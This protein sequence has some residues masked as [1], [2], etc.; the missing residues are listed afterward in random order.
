MEVGLIAAHAAHMSLP[1][2]IEEVFNMPTHN[3]AQ[4]LRLDNYG[5]KEGNRADLVVFDTKTAVDAIRLQ[6]DRR[7]VIKEGRII[8]ES[9]SQSKIYRG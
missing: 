9:S 8:A 3:A 7:F 4:I 1:E 6:P 5:I 2:E